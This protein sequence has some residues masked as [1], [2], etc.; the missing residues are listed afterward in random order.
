MDNDVMMG[1]MSLDFIR[2][3][4]VRKRMIRIKLT[5]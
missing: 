2:L 4:R 5:E 1:Q 3:R